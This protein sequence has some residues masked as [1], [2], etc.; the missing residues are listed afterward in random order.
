MKYLICAAAALTIHALL[1]FGWRDTLFQKAKLVV[2]NQPEAEQINLVS[3]PPAGTAQKSK[4]A[5]TPAATPK[6]T[7]VPIPEPTPKPLS[8][9]KSTPLKPIKPTKPKAEKAA[10][11]PKKTTRSKQRHISK[12]LEKSKTKKDSHTNGSSSA[13]HARVT[14]HASLSRN[15]PP[16]Y[17]EISRRNGEQG[18]VTLTVKVNAEGSVNSVRVVRS[19]GYPRLDVAAKQAARRWRF[20][21][22]RAAGIP[23]PDT[24]TVP[25][26]FDLR[27]K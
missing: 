3:A 1:L 2:E 8:A 10:Q 17:P 6:P 5:I 9:P 13:T 27:N 7:P 15:S 4:P 16:V 11:F 23:V 14:A 24:I 26:R 19:S 18:T 12:K 21:P 25:V 20:H 22:A